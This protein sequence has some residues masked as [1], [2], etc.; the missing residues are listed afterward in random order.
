MTKARISLTIDDRLLERVDKLAQDRHITRS[1]LIE[2]LLR[3]SVTEEEMLG[4]P[5]IRQMVSAAIGSPAVLRSLSRQFENILNDEQ[6]GPILDRLRELHRM[7]Q[8]NVKPKGK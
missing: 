8:R 1:A 3:E 5:L 7:A 2:R 6:V 4:N